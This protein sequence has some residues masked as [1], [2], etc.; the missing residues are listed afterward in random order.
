M[1]SAAPAARRE[2]RARCDQARGLRRGGEQVADQVGAV[3]ILVNNAASPGATHA[4]RARGRDQRLERHH[5]HQP[6]RACSTSP[7][8]SSAPCARPRDGSSISAR[9]S[10]HASAHPELAGLYRLQARRARFY[11]ALAAELVRMACASMRSPRLHRDAAEREGARDQSGPDQG[12]HGPHPSRPRRQAGG[13][14]RPRGV[15]CSEL[16]AYVSGSIVMVDG[17]YRTI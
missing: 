16:S 5:R 2:L 3:S 1:R 6:H 7:M 4:G 11:Q 15:P 12:V 9:S 10:P 8:R 13:H 14:R 17:G